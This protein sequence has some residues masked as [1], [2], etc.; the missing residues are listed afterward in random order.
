MKRILSAASA[1]AVVIAVGVFA[2]AESAVDT[3]EEAAVVYLTE[4][5]KEASPDTGVGSVAA[6]A[7]TAILAGGVMLFATKKKN[8]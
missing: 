8:R 7:G 5:E 3:A 1:L 4:N 6:V 2:C